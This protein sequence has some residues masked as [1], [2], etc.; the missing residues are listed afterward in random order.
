MTQYERL[1]STLRSFMLRERD[2]PALSKATCELLA[3]SLNY[4]S[5][6]L[7]LI[8]DHDHQAHI[9]GMAGDRPE[10]QTFILAQEAQTGFSMACDD[11]A[12]VVSRSMAQGDRGEF[13]FE[14][15]RLALC[16][17]GHVMGELHACL[18]SDRT[19]PA[20][21]LQLLEIVASDTAAAINRLR[22]DQQRERLVK[23]VESLR[24][25]GAEM[26]SGREIK[27]LFQTLVQQVTTLLGANAGGLYICEPEKRQVRCVVSHLTDHDYSGTVLPY[28]EGAAGIAAETGEPLIIPNYARWDHRS[29]KF[30][31]S[32]F[33][34]VMS[35]PMRW[36]GQVTGVIHVLRDHST[37]PFSQA[38]C[39]LL[40]LYA[41][42]AAVVL[43]NARLLEDIKKRVLQLGQLTDLSQS[44]MLAGNLEEL[45]TSYTQRLTNMMGADR[46]AFFQWDSELKAPVLLELAGSNNTPD[47]IPGFQVD[48]LKIIGA[49]L[50]AGTPLVV[51]SALGPPLFPEWLGEAWEA[52]TLLAAPV[53]D[54]QTWQGVAL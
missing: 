7:A 49:A 29:R 30:A 26:I 25:L 11:P 15:A 14:H 28:G 17:E 31:T 42:Q 18:D 21:E 46:W 1:L 20:E 5:I 4:C 12:V 10:L 39:D 22:L 36:Q 27:A 34:A 37:Q 19:Y 44:V 33:H 40:M 43:E 41:N 35:V 52:K 47:E 2:I 9:I 13:N 48:D 50:E 24:D 16:H 3:S 32:S 53:T 23:E 51:E 54:G 45:L 38:D 8:E 6:W